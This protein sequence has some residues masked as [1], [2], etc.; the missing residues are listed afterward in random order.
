M[1]KL[2]SLEIITTQKYQAFSRFECEYITFYNLKTFFSQK[3]T[4]TDLT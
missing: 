2:I 3:Q 1:A 4:E